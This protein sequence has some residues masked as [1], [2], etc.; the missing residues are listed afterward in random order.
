[1]VKRLCLL[2]VCVLMASVA[3]ADPIV[4]WQGDGEVRVSNAE[5]PGQLIPPPGTPL[6]LTLAYNP[7]QA[8]SFG[9]PGGP[10]CLM[11]PVSSASLMIGAY[12]Y[13]AAPGSI[14]FSNSQLPGTNCMGGFTEF[15]LHSLETPSE[16]PWSLDSGG[17]VIVQFFD[18]IPIDSVPSGPVTTR[19]SVFYTPSLLGLSTWN[20]RGSVDLELVQP[21]TPV[22][23]PGTMTLLALGLALAARKARARSK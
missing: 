20:F 4:I 23:E 14:G 15:S 16:S 13:H 6:S 5:F 22:P 3:S 21:L 10:P 18:D 12:T 7:T 11:V 2:V 17:V 9:P 19:V 1:M 8:T